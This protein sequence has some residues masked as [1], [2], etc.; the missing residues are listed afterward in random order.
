[1]SVEEKETVEQNSGFEPTRFLK[2]DTMKAVPQLS[3]SSWRAN[4]PAPT[5]RCALGG[6][7]GGR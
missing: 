3:L 6:Q 1:M 5:W 4:P 7:K 2:R